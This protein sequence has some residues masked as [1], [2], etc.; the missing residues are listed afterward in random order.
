MQLSDTVTLTAEGA[1]A[2]IR[3]DNPPVNA[4]GL[5]VRKGLVAAVDWL[6]AHPEVTGAALHAAGRTFIA[7]ADIR[8]FGKPPVDPWLPEVCNI[9]EGS[10][11]P[12]ACILH[13]TTL[14]GGLEVAMACH[15]RIA[16]PG[17]RVGLPEVL[18]GIL[19]GAG[20]TQRAPRL[21][22]MGFAVEMITTGRHIPAEEAQ[23]AGLIDVLTD[24]TNP[25]A[26]ARAAAQA[27]ADGTLPHRRTGDLTV[28][29]DPEALDA[30]R[31]RIAQAQPHLFSPLK[32]VEAVAAS[33]LPLAEGLAEERSLFRQCMDS[34]QRAGLIHAFFAERAVAK[35]PEAQVPPRDIAQV[36]VIGA[37]TMGSGIA[38][39]C[40]LAGLEVAL[41]DRS[42]DALDRARTAIAANLDGAVKRGKLAVGAQDATLAKLHTGTALDTVAQADLV[43]EAA[44][45]DMAVKQE[46][47]RALDKVARPGAV[48]ATNTS[49]LDVNAIAAVTARPGD[50]LGLH[51]FSPAHVMRLVEVVVAGATTPETAATGFALAKRLR[52][53][54]VRSGV[55]D[56]FIG[57]RILMATRRAVEG[58]LLEGAGIAQIDAAIEGAGWAM[59]P[60]RVSDL[61]GL[62]IAWAQRKRQA[63]T[64]PAGERV[65]ALLDR[66]CE[67]GMV[68][69]KAGAGYY[70]PDGSPNPE[71]L[72]LLEEERAR[73][74]LTPRSFDADEIVTRYLTAMM[75]EATGIVDEGIAL[76]PIDVDAVLLFGYGFPRHLGGPLLQADR[77]GAGEVAARIARFAQGDPSFWTVPPLLERM[78][79]DGSRF[80]D[81]NG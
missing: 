10:P 42:K 77:V 61:A 67:Q 35:V 28:T 23:A 44:F 31:A 49:Y 56:G 66:L 50:V 22:G 1:I 68:G 2:L 81:R 33:T 60:F 21:A 14:G 16:L 9:L 65:N 38:T 20:G 26:A 29:P 19:P 24:E 13:G 11:T 52:K 80:A 7:G 6:R 59:G 18:L 54:A 55:C 34:P 41:T 37:G 47:F 64:R 39:A 57:N 5:T 27:L 12:I 70:L 25:E 75:M 71:A 74:G 46:I 36:G 15:A 51:F 8:E 79:Q 17:A 58:M 72:R 73:H 43:I 40:L 32:C 69:R 63:A 78:A 76:R 53:I 3:V 45:E 30:A 48:L 62:D 4:A